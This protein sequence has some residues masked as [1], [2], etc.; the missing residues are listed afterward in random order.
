MQEKSNAIPNETRTARTKAALIEAAR[1]LFVDK[2]Y[3]ATGTPE[4]VKAAG[5]TRGALYHHY[6]DKLDLFRAIIERESA[7]VATAIETASANPQT[8]LA[9]LK[10]GARAYFEAMR[11]PGRTRLLLVDGPSVL[12]TDAMHAIDAASSGG[13]LAAGL[14]IGMDSGEI[15]PVP[16][17]ALASVLSA[18]FDRAALDIAEG[19]SPYDIIAAIDALLDGLR[20]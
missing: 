19:A 2:G 6:A 8:A 18:A 12:G 20:A 1:Q 13:S 11:V 16:V 17:A 7:A 9:A 5:V 4:L 14:Q 15:R 3:A 10:S